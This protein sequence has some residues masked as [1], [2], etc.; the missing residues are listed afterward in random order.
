MRTQILWVR[1]LT[2]TAM[3]I[4]AACTQHVDI[5]QGTLSHETME[6][7]TQAFNAAD[8]TALLATYTA[9]AV[10]YPPNAEA[11][12]GHDGVRAMFGGGLKQGLKAMQSTEVLEVRDDMA[13]RAGSFVLQ[14]AAGKQ[15]DRGKFIEL[16]R[17]GADGTWKMSHDMW[18]SSN[19]PATSAPAAE[20]PAPSPQE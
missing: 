17:K 19:P 16:W 3:T 15:L 9:D 13:F 8:E 1:I 5:K 10:L 2:A 20:N 7:W 18:N 14:D 6:A 12:K 11:V 4:L